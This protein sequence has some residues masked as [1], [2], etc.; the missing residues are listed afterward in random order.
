ME[1]GT[2]LRAQQFTDW[3]Y[4][5]TAI[6]VGGKR[7]TFATLLQVPKPGADGEDVHLPSGIVDVVLAADTEADGVQQ[8]GERRAVG[9]LAAVSHV[10]WSGGVR[11]NELQH[12]PF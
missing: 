3:L 10:Q 1:L 12:D 8:V 4:V 9:G 5:V 11:R 7:N 6:A 2:H